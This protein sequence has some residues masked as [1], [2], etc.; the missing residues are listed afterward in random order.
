M[1]RQPTRYP[2]RT[3]VGAYGGGR[4]V[5]RSVLH[6]FIAALH[7]TDRNAAIY[8]RNAGKFGS[9]GMP[10]LGFDVRIVDDDGARAAE[11]RRCALAA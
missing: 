4:G 9:V 2:R 5:L 11:P 6:R 8:R 10:V 7:Q 1:R 3:H